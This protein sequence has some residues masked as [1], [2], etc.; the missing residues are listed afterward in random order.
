M[1]TV[2]GDAI[3]ERFEIKISKRDDYKGEK[4]G[5]ITTH[6]IVDLSTNEEVCVASSAKY[7]IFIV[8]ALNKA[9]GTTTS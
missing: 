5:Q 4:Y 8:T 9:C 3:I 2:R 1:V 6:K 7:A